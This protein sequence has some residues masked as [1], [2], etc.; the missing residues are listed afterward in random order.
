MRRLPIG[1]TRIVGAGLG[2]LAYLVDTR[3]RRITIANLNLALGEERSPVELRKIARTC[4]ANLGRSVAEF[5]H[6]PS[7]NEKTLSRWASYEGL[8]N[9]SSAYKRGKGIIFITAHFGNWE[10]LAYA[11]GIIGHPSNVIIRPLDNKYLNKLV[12]RY[13]SISGNRLI[14]KKEAAKDILRALHKGE[15]VGILIDQNVSVGE[16]V[17]VDF[18]GQPASTITA[19][20]ILAQR[21]GAAVIP[22][23]IV[24]QPKGKHKIIFEPEIPLQKSGDRQQDIQYNMQ[25][26]TNSVEKYVRKYPEQWFWMHRRWKTKPK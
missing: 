5:C 17:F 21:T 19:P 9:L 25:Q 16:R 1:A 3:H 7:I 10:L 15:G 14:P 22:G 13:R 4:Y 18:F 24:R 2:Y 12:N 23:F 26:F 8:E 11:Q 20:A 6:L